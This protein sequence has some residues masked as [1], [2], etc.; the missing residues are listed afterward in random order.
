MSDIAIINKVDTATPENVEL[1][2]RNIGR[3]A[4]EADIILAESPLLVDDPDRIRG[5]RVLV[6]E[7]GP[8]LTHGGM[9]FGAATLAARQYGAKEIVDPRPYAVRSIAETYLRN[10]HLGVALPA[11]GYSPSQINDLGKTINAVDCD[12]VIIATP[13]N[14]SCIVPI[15]K[16]VVRVRYEYGDHGTPLLSDVLSARLAEKGVL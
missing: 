3:Y 10:P 2:R 6:V 1:V 14:L 9:P 12:L 13:I 7:D 5:K 4:P 11:M 8:T 16:P 15:E